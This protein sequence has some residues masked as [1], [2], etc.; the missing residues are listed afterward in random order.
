MPPLM[1]T[2]DYDVMERTL[3]AMDTVVTNCKDQFNKDNV[4]AMLN[5]QIKKWKKLIAEDDD[6]SF[7]SDLIDFSVKLQNK[8]AVS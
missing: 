6:N 8:L 7:Y 1:Q 4:S 3:E 5:N 2:T